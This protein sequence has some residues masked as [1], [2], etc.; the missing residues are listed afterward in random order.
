MP[1]IDLPEEGNKMEFVN[2]LSPGT[3]LTADQ[4]N[5]RK[6]QPSLA[7]H[8]IAYCCRPPHA[9]VDYHL[10]FLTIAC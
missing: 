4:N 2:A 7:Q 1:E 5:S 10:L 8:F 6:S 3:H 9:V